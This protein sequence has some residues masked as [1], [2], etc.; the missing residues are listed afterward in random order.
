MAGCAFLAGGDDV[1][2]REWKVESN[3]LDGQSVRE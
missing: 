2:R 3:G 1:E